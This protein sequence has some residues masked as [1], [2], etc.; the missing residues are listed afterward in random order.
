MPQANGDHAFDP[1]GH[2][3]DRAQKIW[4]EV[5]PRR[6]MSLERRTLFQVALECLDRADQASAAIDEAGL[7]FVTKSTGAVHINPLVRIEKDSR[8]AF[9]KTWQVLGLEWFTALD[10][11]GIRNF[12]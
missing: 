11:S 4:R 5:Q 12:D 6:C 8:A 7:T 2:L 9:A 3:S 10:G 1:P